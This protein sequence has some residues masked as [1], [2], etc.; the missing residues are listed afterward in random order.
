MVVLGPGGGSEGG[1]VTYQGKPDRCPDGHGGSAAG[2]VRAPSPGVEAEVVAVKDLSVNNVRGAAFSVP[3][4]RLTAVVGVSGAGKS[5][6][7]LKGLVPAAEAALAGGVTMGGCSLS[8]PKCIKFVEVI[9]Q[10]ML[11]QNRRSVVATALELFDQLREHF[12]GLD[13]S[14]SLGLKAANFSFNSDGACEACGG[15]GCARDSDGLALPLPWILTW[16]VSGLFEWGSTKSH[17]GAAALR[18]QMQQRRRCRSGSSS[19]VGSFVIQTQRT[20]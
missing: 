6:A 9:A 3:V 13:A 10:R 7:I 16:R 8:L 19:T 4:G 5:S 14:R 12:A 18:W 17:V 11:G 2:S 1:R 20:R 15:A